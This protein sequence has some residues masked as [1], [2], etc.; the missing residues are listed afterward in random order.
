MR[1]AAIDLSDNARSG[2]RPPDAAGSVSSLGQ[3]GTIGSRADLRRAIEHTVMSV[4]GVSRD[5]IGIANRGVARVALA[6]QTA[7]YLAHTVGGLS[8]TDVGNMFERDRT[9][10]A[11]ACAVVE[12]R[13]DDPNFDRA[14]E[15]L[16][17]AVV[18]IL[19]RRAIQVPSFDA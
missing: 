11:H 12:D 8:L 3:I 7:M 1:E 2:L 19:T 13:R 4:F 14:V 15:L 16:E 17:R 5:D 9:T 10:V 18:R 6:R